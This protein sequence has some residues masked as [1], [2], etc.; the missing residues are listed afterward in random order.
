M[1]RGHH[2][3]SAAHLLWVAIRET[4]KRFGSIPPKS[5]SLVAGK[6]H[7]DQGDQILS[8]LGLVDVAVIDADLDRHGSEAAE[9]GGAIVAPIAGVVANLVAGEELVRPVLSTTKW[10][11]TLLLPPPLKTK[12]AHLGVRARILVSGP[13]MVI[14]RSP[15]N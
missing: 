10:K 1:C 3:L 2:F 15:V 8:R 11:E 9:V 7:G 12:S 6:D 14:Q 5:I 13:W 4:E